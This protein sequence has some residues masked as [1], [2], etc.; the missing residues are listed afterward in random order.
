MHDPR[1]VILSLPGD[2]RSVWAQRGDEVY[3]LCVS[4]NAPGAMQRLFE[5]FYTTKPDGVGLG[6]A[7]CKRVIE[8]HGG[9]IDAAANAD[10]RGITVG[11]TVPR[12]PA[13]SAA[14]AARG[15]EEPA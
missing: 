2:V 14:P 3:L 15:I 13:A 6:L 8:A 5:P 10:G 1:T 4:E 11:F 12:A 9:H 7:I